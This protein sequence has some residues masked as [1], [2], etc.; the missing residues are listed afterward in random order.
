MPELLSRPYVE[1]TALGDRDGI[2][3]PVEWTFS[4]KA[5]DTPAD[6]ALFFCAGN[7]SNGSMDPTGDFIFSA[8]DTVLDVTTPVRPVTWGALKRRYRD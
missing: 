1:Q 4:W 2:A 7:A 3:S 6:T 5:P 8:A